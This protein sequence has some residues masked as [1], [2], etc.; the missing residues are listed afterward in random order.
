MLEKKLYKIHRNVRC[1]NC[2]SKGAV[3]YYGTYYPQGIQNK[4]NDKSEFV[5]KLYADKKN[6]PY[7]SPAIGFG[8]T[9]PCECLNCGEQ[10]L[11][12]IDMLEGYKKLFET[13]ND[14]EKEKES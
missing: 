1:I 4:L 3:E 5:Q 13:I 10:G 6:K 11:I 12:D 9:I 8:G 7:M 14:N 2:G